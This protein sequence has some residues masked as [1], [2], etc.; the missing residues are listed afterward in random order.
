M[1]DSEIDFSDIPETTAADWEDAIRN[2]YM[3][4]DQKL[5]SAMVDNDVLDWLKSDGPGYRIR[6]NA[7]LRDAMLRAQGKNVDSQPT[8][9]QNAQQ[10]A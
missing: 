8:E 10:A 1:D 9:S 4:P 2:P 6:V 3:N 7:I 5:T